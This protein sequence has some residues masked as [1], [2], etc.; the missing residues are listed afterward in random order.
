MRQS[1]DRIPIILVHVH[2]KKVCMMIAIVILIMVKVIGI[3]N[4]AMYES[5][6]FTRAEARGRKNRES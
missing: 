6:A 3:M 1:A 4:S 2:I 5:I